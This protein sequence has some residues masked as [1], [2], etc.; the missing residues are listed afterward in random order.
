[1]I[2]GV[3]E[4]TNAALCVVEVSIWD[5]ETGELIYAF[6][7]TADTPANALAVLDQFDPCAYLPHGHMQA[8]DLPEIRTRYDERLRR[9]RSEAL[10]FFND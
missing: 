7:S 6:A 3:D 10:A 5:E 8:H 2:C 1:L 9:F 4:K